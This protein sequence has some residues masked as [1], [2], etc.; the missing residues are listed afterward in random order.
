MTTLSDGRDSLSVPLRFSHLKQ[1][2]RSPAH[3]LWSLANEIPVTPAMRLGTLT[4]SITLGTPVGTIFEGERRGNVWK[5][6][7]LA[8][9]G[10][11]IFSSKEFEAAS[12]M[13][14]AVLN[15]AEAR[16]LLSGTFEET[17]FFE[18]AG[19]KC[20]ATPDS[21]GL[22]LGELK[23]TTDASPA[24]FPWTALR[25]G[26]HAQLAFYTDAARAAG[27]T[28][29][30]RIGAVAVETKPPF[31]VCVYGLTDDALEFGRRTYV[32]WIEAFLNCERSDSFPSYPA[33]VLDSPPDS[34]LGLVFGDEEE[35]LAS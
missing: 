11:E 21:L 34:D 6:F 18:Y 13:A 25:L 9:E 22:D 35:E 33:A 16:E 5:D 4:H 28:S 17:L 10:E 2:A 23:S 29:P 8:H 30:R 27:K 26:Y 19:R 1:M 7:K 20:R 32:G 12:C 15:H 3:A 24:R 31:A 14:A